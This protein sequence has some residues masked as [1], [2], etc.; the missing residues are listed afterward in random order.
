[1]INPAFITES[2]NN[3]IISYHS[4]DNEIKALRIYNDNK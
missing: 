2:G 3:L 4:E 1:M